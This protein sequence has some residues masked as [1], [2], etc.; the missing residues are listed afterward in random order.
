M[1]FSVLNHL[2]RL[3]FSFSFSFFFPFLFFFFFPAFFSSISTP[4][5]LSSEDEASSALDSS[6]NHGPASAPQAACV[7]PRN[8]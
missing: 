4:A 7:P 1:I 6:P 5:A 2:L 3:S 8:S